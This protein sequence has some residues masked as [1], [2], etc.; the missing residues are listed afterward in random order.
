MPDIKG[1]PTYKVTVP[2]Y[3]WTIEFYEPSVDE[4]DEIKE[5]RDEDDNKKLYSILTKL[6]KS[7]DATDR[8]GRP[9]PINGAG[10]GKMPP[11]AIVAITAG[12]A[13]PRGA[14]P[15]DNTDTSIS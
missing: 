9:L 12:F 4:I 13:N 11:T 8:E 5:A 1:W 14:D 6:I 3:N 7:W 10:Y 2:D 15:K